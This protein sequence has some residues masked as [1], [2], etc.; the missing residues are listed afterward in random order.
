MADN[1]PYKSPESVEP[2][3]VKRR[4]LGSPGPEDFVSY[5]RWVGVG[6]LAGLVALLVYL[7]FVKPLIAVFVLFV[8]VIVILELYLNPH[9]PDRL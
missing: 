4:R 9:H 6:V 8:V 3:P 5:L 1:N 2:K 7:F